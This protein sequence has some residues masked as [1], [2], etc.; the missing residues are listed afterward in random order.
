MH[1]QTTADIKIHILQQF[2]INFLPRN[3]QILGKNHKDTNRTFRV[4]RDIFVK[5]KFLIFLKRP[6]CGAG[7]INIQF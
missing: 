4:R 1:E 7:D 2:W 3:I 6:F 5:L